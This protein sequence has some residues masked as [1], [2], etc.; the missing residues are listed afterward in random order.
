MQ[1]KKIKLNFKISKSVLALGTQ[2]KNTVCFLKKN[3]AVLSAKPRD[4]NNPKA[5]LEFEK[6]AKKF[7]KSK[8]SIIAFDLHPDYQST[9]F[10]QRFPAAKFTLKPIQH[11]HAHIASCMAENNLN[12]Q[13]V[14]GVA[15]DGTG[16]GSDNKLWG[17]EF[18]ICDYQGFKR[19]AHLQEIPLLAGEQAILEPWRV[20][21]AW[22]YT[23][24]KDNF[25]KLK[26]GFIA[27]VNKKKW[28]ILKNMYELKFNS[29][30]ASS[31]GRLFDAASSL[32]LE[33]DK[34]N[35]EAEL[36]I[37]LERLATKS[38]FR[39]ESYRVELR[40]VH[41]VYIIDPAKMFKA[42][43]VDLK[44]KRPK[45]EIAYKF[46]F[47]IAKIIQDVC[48]K[49]KKDTGIQRIALSG[50]VFQ[51]KLLLKLA[52]R[53]LYKER[54]KIFIHQNIPANDAG[55]SLGQAVIAGLT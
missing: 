30:Y 48:L 28:N 36:A 26:I 47:T 43:V 37:Q 49:L 46:H 11:H 1:A 38:L 40:K 23:I 25:L 31:I 6:E 12:N 29:P 10:A 9:K 7:L 44:D 8:P 24:Y 42:I 33:K 52:L 54:F 3:Y 20:A 16:L 2:T 51:N 21:A 50:G 13:K 14:I 19:A 45:A 27:K 22:L 41:G 5:C 34:A 4:L 17:A 18:L 55:I 39:D 35:Y 32:I 15:F 53:L